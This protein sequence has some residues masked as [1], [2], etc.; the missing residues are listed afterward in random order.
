MSSKQHEKILF[1]GVLSYTKK[2]GHDFED[3]DHTPYKIKSKILKVL[4]IYSLSFTVILSMHT[5]VNKTYLLLVSS[6]AL[7]YICTFTFGIY[8]NFYL[9]RYR[10]DIK[11][12]IDSLKRLSNRGL[13]DFIFLLKGGSVMCIL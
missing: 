5:V 4:V 3:Q 6:Q 7:G 12:L 2:L 11:N 10:T 1:S 13:Y 9:T 8:R